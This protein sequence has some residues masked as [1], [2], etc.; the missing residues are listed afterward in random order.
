MKLL[1]P[2]YY[3]SFRCTAGACRH[4]CCVGWEIG[5]DADTLAFYRTVPGELGKK[6]TENISLAEDG[7]CFRLTPDERCPFLGRDG[8][9][10]IITALGEDGLCQICADHPRFRNFF[11]GRTELG[12]GLCCEAAGRLILGASQPM[13][14][15]V[16]EDGGKEEP[17]S[18]EEQAFLSLRDRVFSLL[19][20]RTVPLEERVRRMLSVCGGAVPEQSPA[21]WAELYRGLE[22]LDPAWDSALL[23]LRELPPGGRRELCSWDTAWEQ[24]LV[25]FIYRHLAGALDDGMLSARAAFAAQSLFLIRDLCAVRLRNCGQLVLDDVVEAARLYSSEVEYSEENLQTLLTMFQKGET[26]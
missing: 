12:L 3:S 8:L 23:G 15:L 20:D 16:L 4:S 17:L 11:S 19:Q 18:R 22:R 5:I 1:V 6:L 10:G 26:L 25:Y 9:C 21:A 14:L 13:K 7:P 24:L 2:Q